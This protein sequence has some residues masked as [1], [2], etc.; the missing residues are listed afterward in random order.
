MQKSQSY[1]PI[2][3]VLTAI[4]V[5]LLGAFLF[6]RGI[7]DT[8][9]HWHLETGKLIAETHSIP[10]TDPFSFTAEGADWVTHEWLFELTTWILY[11]SGGYPF[12]S[13]ATLI[14][15]ITSMLILVNINRLSGSAPIWTL[16][17]TLLGML[18]LL[19]RVDWR[20]LL[21]TTGLFSIYICVLETYIRT[22]NKKVLWLLPV[23]ML[24]W[25][26]WHSGLLFG[27]LLIAYYTAWE[28]LKPPDKKSTGGKASVLGMFLL[29]TFICSIANPNFIDTLLYPVRLGAFYSNTYLKM[30]VVRE[31][32]SLTPDR[33]PVFWL[34]VVLLLFGLLFS[35][36]TMN[37]RIA[38]LLFALV[39]ASIYRIRLTEIY[40][41][42]LIAFGPGI[43]QN[44][45]IIIHGRFKPGIA[46]TFNYSLTIF[47]IAAS[48]MMAQKSLDGPPSL[49]LKPDIYPVN[50]AGWVEQFSPPG[51]MYNNFGYGGY[52][53]HR[54]YPGHRIFWDGRLLVFQDLFKSLSEGKT[55]S[56]IHQVDYSIDS[57]IQSADSPYIPDLWALV[58]FD[59]TSALYIKRDG[60]ASGLID[61]HEFFFIGPYDPE[62]NLR[63]IRDYPEEIR[64]GLIEETERFLSENNSDYTKSFAIGVYL[65]I[66]GKY[67][68]DALTLLNEGMSSSQNY[69]GYWHN[70]A[71]YYYLKGDYTKAKQAIRPIFFWYPNLL[72]TKFLYARII[73]RE[74][75]NRG[76]ITDFKKLAGLGYRTPQLYFELANSY[77]IVGD[78]S[79]AADALENYFLTVLPQDYE[80]GE[81][82]SAIALGIELM[83]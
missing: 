68:S 48:L 23:L 43:M 10:K 1:I 59:P 15:L 18:I 69:P 42:A 31:L 77:Y 78:K 27:L 36:K 81:Y 79:L 46:S 41:P 74:G 38:L 82:A 33:M 39:I 9:L 24:I 14:F 37:R 8:D 29:I 55:I 52:L 63:N 34:S 20:P 72:K 4:A 58:D 6:A 50:C 54:L 2:P 67:T 35:R 56:D 60:A 80:T 44:I 16:I 28:W 3:W 26:N 25:A 7:R 47:L 13:T 73:A 12:L 51:F 71:Y 66:G 11:K 75:N 5:T 57:N 53:T 19:I 32:E 83:Q 62:D 30:H 61:G 22:E 64:D 70:I 49:E 65:A 17:C 21:M 45:T 76:A 40:V